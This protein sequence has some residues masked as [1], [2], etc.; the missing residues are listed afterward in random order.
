M[1]TV[2]TFSKVSCCIYFPLIFTVQFMISTWDRIVIIVT[3]LQAEQLRHPG[4][5]SVMV[6]DF[7]F[8]KASILAVR[9]YPATCWVGSRGSYPRGKSAEAWSLLSIHVVPKFRM[10]ECII[11]TSCL[12]GMYRI[13]FQSFL[14]RTWCV[15]HCKV[16]ACQI[17]L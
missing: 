8:S 12:H 9:M 1:S 3:S 10:R 6:R 15:C 2:I 11:S 4:F 13:S 7:Y 17:T 16:H 14:P 5:F